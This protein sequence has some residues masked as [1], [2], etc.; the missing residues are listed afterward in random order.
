MAAILEP[1]RLPLTVTSPR[2]D[3]RSVAGGR[4]VRSVSAGTGVSPGA[5][6]AVVLLLV[7][8]VG[9]VLALG[10]GAFAGLAPASPAAA[11]TLARGTTGSETVV[12]RSGDTLWSI[13]RSL[14]PTGDV[15]SLVDQLVVTNGSTTVAPGDRI[16]L[17]S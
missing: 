4:A 7:L 3:L 6:A 11:S 5:V 17:P 16:T 12:V 13:A 15:R 10:R 8:V 1:H 14:Q 2:P 9:G